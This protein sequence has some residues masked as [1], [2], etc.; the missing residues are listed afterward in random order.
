MATT[1]LASPLTGTGVELSL[2]LPLPNWPTS[3]LPQHLTAPPLARAQ[4]CS[5]PAA[6]AVTPL[7]RPV[8]ST[9]VK[10]AAVLLSP[11]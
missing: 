2:K 10:R 8:T 7:L 6:T 9:G 4:L 11:N 1:P 5:S 3:F